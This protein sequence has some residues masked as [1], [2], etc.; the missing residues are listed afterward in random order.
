MS[1]GSKR[2]PCAA[3]SLLCG[4][5]LGASVVSGGGACA[6]ADKAAGASAKPTASERKIRASCQPPERPPRGKPL[7]VF[8][9]CA[10][11]PQMVRLPGGRFL[12]GEIGAV[13]LTYELPVHEVQVPPFSM[14]RYEVSFLEWDDCHASSFCRNDR[15]IWAGD[16]GFDR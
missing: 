1:V 14:G 12:M 16:A 13:G 6:A 3:F 8:R 10:D 9:D 4:L 7:E 11:T 5:V 15:M 2:S